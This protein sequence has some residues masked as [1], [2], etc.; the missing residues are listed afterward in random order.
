MKELIEECTNVWQNGRQL[1]EAVSLNGHA[2][3]YEL[4]RVPT[5]NEVELN[6]SSLLK[7][8]TS[9]S[10]E[11]E[12]AKIAEEEEASSQ[13]ESSQEKYPLKS[14]SYSQNRSRSH[15]SE[16]NRRLGR[17][18]NKSDRTSSSGSRNKALP[19]KNHSSN[20]ITI[21][22][23]NCGEFQL[24][25]RDPFDLKEANFTFYEEF[26]NM[27]AS[28]KKKQIKYEFNV[29]K[30]KH[31]AS[32]Y[33]P[34]RMMTQSFSL[35]NQINL[36]LSQED[37]F[38]KLSKQTNTNPVLG[39][40]QSLNQASKEMINFPSPLTEHQNQKSVEEQQQPQEQ[41]ISPIR[42]TQIFNTKVCEY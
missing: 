32:Q 17:H 22:A 2:C 20:I 7:E 24:E 28:A 4:H 33:Q 31:D 13:A 41:S 9:E 35:S 37:Q 21:A 1:C 30:S 6:D 36:N 3:V 14:N 25:R 16:S 10:N 29:F 27:A 38:P 8:K 15:R 40:N 23:S 5:G 18:I 42:A 26:A 39:Q 19:I 12:E 11:D 34:P